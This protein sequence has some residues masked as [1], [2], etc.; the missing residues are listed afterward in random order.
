MFGTRQKIKLWLKMRST[1]VQQQVNSSQ[2]KT[3]IGEVESR[4]RILDE[5]W[6]KSVAELVKNRDKARPVEESGHQVRE[7]GKSDITCIQNSFSRDRNL[8]GHKQT[9]KLKQL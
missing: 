6:T 2:R 4:A 9:L 1:T 3:N 5:T 8:E 7:R